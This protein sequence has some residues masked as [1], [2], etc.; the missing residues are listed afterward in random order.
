MTDD[1][2]SLTDT[3]AN[4]VDGFKQLEET[5]RGMRAHMLEQGWGQEVAEGISANWLQAIILKS[6]EAS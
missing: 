2:P 5:A 1:A 6:V 3:L 4:A